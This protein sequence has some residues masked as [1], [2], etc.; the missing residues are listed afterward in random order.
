MQGNRCGIL[1]GA[2]TTAR[3][4]DCSHEVYVNAIILVVAAIREF[5]PP[6]TFVRV[7]QMQKRQNV[8]LVLLIVIIFGLTFGAVWSSKPKEAFWQKAYG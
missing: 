8:A 1:P 7:N 6:L 4:Q 3:F 2:T 5:W